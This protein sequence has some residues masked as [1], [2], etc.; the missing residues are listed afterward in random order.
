M[1]DKYVL[2]VEKM[3][4]DGM[5]TR[6]LFAVMKGE[7]KQEAAEGPSERTLAFIRRFA[8]DCKPV[9]SCEYDLRV[10]IVGSETKM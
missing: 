1:K 6:C 3:P 10:H 8:R 2:C 5:F 9:V 4:M 7:E